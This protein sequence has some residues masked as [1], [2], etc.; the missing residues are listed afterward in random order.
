MEIKSESPKDN[1]KVENRWLT[2]NGT[3]F[4]SVFV[5]DIGSIYARTL[6]QYRSILGPVFESDINSLI[7]SGVGNH[8]CIVDAGCASCTALMDLRKLLPTAQLIGLDVRNVLL[9]KLKTPQ[10]I[11]NIDAL[12][13]KY[14]ITFLR[15]SYTDIP[16]IVPDGYNRLF[17]VG[18]FPDESDHSDV[19]SKLLS[20][21]YSGLRGGG[22][23]FIHISA[24][25]D[26]IRHI[27]QGMDDS[28]ITYEFLPVNKKVLQK[29]ALDLPLE[30]QGTL[31]LKK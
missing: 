29:H 12:L 1:H 9:N 5:A 10:G 25:E 30:L 23:A 11:Y 26:S 14:S 17:C 16:D 18:S 2:E 21:F 15:Q 8:M 22:K 24:T 6:E 20:K 3:K 31:I 27:K 4:D 28:G 19:R 13:K 7:K